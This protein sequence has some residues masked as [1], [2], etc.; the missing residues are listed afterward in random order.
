MKKDFFEGIQKDTYANRGAGDN[1]KDAI[2]KRVDIKNKTAADIGIG[3]G[4]YSI[5][6]AELG[7]ARVIGID[8]AENMLA[9]ARSNCHSYPQIEFQLGHASDTKLKD[10]EVDV[11]LERA[12]I[13]HLTES[14]LKDCFV[15][16][17]RILQ[18]EGVYIIQ[19]RTSEDCLVKGSPEHLRGYFFD[20]YPQLKKKDISRRHSIETVHDTLF[21]SGFREV[22]FFTLWENR[23][24][25]QSGEELRQE[26]LD[27]KGRSILFELNDQQLE[28]LADK[29]LEKA[30]GEFPLQEK[31]RW[32]IWIA[33][34]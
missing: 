5:A 20:I 10:Q 7:A 26:I 1:W 25:Y 17:K 29:I 22:E 18:D 28:V 24:L 34:K 32:T 31:E 11:I 19:D 9:A 6:L 14:Q 15:E 2:R 8:I 13:H 12:L 4:I 16:A 27:R 3:G 33:M 23:K 30:E 21:Q